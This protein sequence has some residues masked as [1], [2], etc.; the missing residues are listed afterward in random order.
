MKVTSNI[1]ADGKTITINIGE[2]FDFSC[3]G[4]FRDAYSA[5]DPAQTKF[6]I[7]FSRTDYLDSAALGMLLVLRERAGGDK[8]DITLEGCNASVRQI[9]DVTR[10]ERLFEIKA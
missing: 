4:E 9:M 1:S 7:N 5:V 8:A 6:I 10:F 3:H 2:R